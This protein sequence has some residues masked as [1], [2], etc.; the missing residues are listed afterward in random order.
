MDKKL[1]EQALMMAP[2]ERV[3]FAELILAS[4]E[5]EDEN[6]R[7]AW[8]REVKER[9]NAVEEGRAKIMDFNALYNAD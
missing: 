6:V 9:I 3:I 8:V 1:L 2:N 5:H 7:L 4:L